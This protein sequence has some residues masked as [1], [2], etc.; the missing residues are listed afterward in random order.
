M[1]APTIDMIGSNTVMQ[2]IR[3]IVKT[4]NEFVDY[5]EEEMKLKNVKL[6]YDSDT[7]TLRLPESDFKYGIYYINL[8]GCAFIVKIDGTDSVYKSSVAYS[9]TYHGTYNT[10][11]YIRVEYDDTS[12]EYVFT[13]Y[14][15]DSSDMKTASQSLHTF[16]DTVVQYFELDVEE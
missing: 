1:T 4:Y 11:Y 7:K 5:V 12:E 6:T 14:E 15:A 3:S 2:K 8:I 9:T 13:L 10:L 16:T